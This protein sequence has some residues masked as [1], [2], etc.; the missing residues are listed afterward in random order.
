MSKKVR[1]PKTL[2]EQ[3][4]KEALRTHR[5]IS[6][7]IEYYFNIGSIAEENPDLSFKL[8]QEILKAD[9]ETETEEYGL[10]E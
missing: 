5:T 4:T 2:I 3:A 10:N 7:Q 1:L 8:I 6:N 9:S